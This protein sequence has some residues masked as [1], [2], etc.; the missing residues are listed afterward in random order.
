MKNRSEV[1]K[2]VSREQSGDHA[3]VQAREKSGL[4]HGGGGSGGDR[5]VG[6]RKYTWGSGRDQRSPSD[7]VP[8]PRD[9]GMNG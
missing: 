6:G 3:K 1:D 5:E 7:F 9:E 2:N 4:D 8:E